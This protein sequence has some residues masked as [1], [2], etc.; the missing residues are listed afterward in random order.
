[1]GARMLATLRRELAAGRL[2]GRVT[3][4]GVAVLAG[5]LLLITPGPLTDVLGLLLILPPWRGL[6]RGA[7]RRSVERSV[8]RGATRIWVFRLDRSDGVVHG[9]KTGDAALGLDP[10]KE[11]RLPPK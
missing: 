9:E 1:Q 8:E 5:S 10:T 2:P 3:L 7:V 4:E 6:V 11:I